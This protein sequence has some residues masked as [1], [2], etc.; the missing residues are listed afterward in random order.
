MKVKGR[1]KVIRPGDIKESK[2]S[3]ISITDE[4]GKQR[5]FKANHP[6]D[7]EWLREVFLKA[8]GK[9]QIQVKPG[10]E[11][12]RPKPESISHPKLFYLFVYPLQRLMSLSKE[13]Y[14]F[15]SSNPE[16]IEWLKE[17]LLKIRRENEI[18]VMP[19]RLAK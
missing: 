17:K 18:V 8:G 15:K 14:A 11:L 16:W 7:V 2:L 3:Y 6:K 10:I 13:Y 1:K 5:I 12:R 4:N 19:K 9:Y